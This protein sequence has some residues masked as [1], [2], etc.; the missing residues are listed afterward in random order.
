M[1]K[2]RR[3]EAEPGA[4]HGGAED[5]ETLMA[6]SSEPFA[7]DRGRTPG[8]C[9]GEA[10]RTGRCHMPEGVGSNPPPRTRRRV[11]GRRR[12]RWPRIIWRQRLG[13]PGDPYLI[14]WVV[15]VGRFSVRL[16]RW[17]G[18]DDL[19]APHDHAWGFW[20]IL[21]AGK[22]WDR[23]PGQSG[24]YTGDRPFLERARRW[25]RPEYFTAEHRHSV[26]VG[27]KGAWSILL[28]G[29]EERE[30]G[31]WTPRRGGP[32]R[33]I[34]RFRHRNKYFHTNGHHDGPKAQR[35]CDRA[36]QAPN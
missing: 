3:P 10:A 33:G 22:M 7:T 2:I 20:S 34:V 18:S 8:S 27:P 11:R 32:D 30:W 17:L 31:F 36:E 21:I 35:A 29:P 12:W 1:A 16:H 6:G 5:R 26:R 15:D 24:G 23:T 28:T 13:K 19:R 4:P 9:R 14:R 25:L